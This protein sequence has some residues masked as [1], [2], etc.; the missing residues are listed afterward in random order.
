MKVR[1]SI[2]MPP[3]FFERSCRPAL[4]YLSADV[5]RDDFGRP[6]MRLR[7]I[8]SGFTQRAPLTQQVPALIQFYL[9]VGQALA[10]CRITRP[11]LEKP[12]LFSHQA[13]DM[14]EHGL[15]LVMFFHGS[16]R[17]MQKGVGAVPT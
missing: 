8:T 7:R 15:V 9:H 10:A 3:P 14:G 1:R 5:I 11:L 17:W 4:R 6:D 2:M 16:P 13:L 12:V